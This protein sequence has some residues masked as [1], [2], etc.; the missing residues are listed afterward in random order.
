[1]SG[2]GEAVGA[3]GWR[4]APARRWITPRRLLFVALVAVTA[5][6]ARSCQQAQ[7][8]VPKARAVA[9]AQARVDFRPQATQVRLVRQ[10][11]NA[12]PFWA[13]SLSVRS[14]G[15]FAELAVVKIDA[16]TGKVIS[17]AD[18]HPGRQRR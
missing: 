3:A 17:V 2:R 9:A 11:L 13:V 4:A 14:D 12:H 10:G 15:G 1:M 8:R 6:A 7:V 18:K 16:N 5:L